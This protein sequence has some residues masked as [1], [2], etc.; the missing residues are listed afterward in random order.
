MHVIYRRKKPGRHCHGTAARR[1]PG[2]IDCA[3]HHL[4]HLGCGENPPHPGG[5]GAAL[6]MFYNSNRHHS[7][8]SYLSPKE[9]EESRLLKKTA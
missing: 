6:G 3:A 1:K 9:F 4:G 2:T 5:M 8:P 7:Y